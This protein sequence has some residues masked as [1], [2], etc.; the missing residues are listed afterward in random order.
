MIGVVNLISTMFRTSVLGV[1]MPR[2][3]T[4]QVIIKMPRLLIK[5]CRCPS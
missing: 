2:S 5:E 4:R 1:A 3:L